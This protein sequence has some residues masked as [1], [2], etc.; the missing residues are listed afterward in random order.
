MQYKTD[1][2]VGIAVYVTQR[3]NPN[4]FDGPL[5]DL[6]PPASQN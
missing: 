2:N 6:P 4:K 1:T 3:M 5:T